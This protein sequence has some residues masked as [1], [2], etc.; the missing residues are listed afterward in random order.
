MG[1]YAPGTQ[2][3]DMANQ[4]GADRRARRSG[5]IASGLL[6]FAG[7]ANTL[8]S[9][10]QRN[11][12]YAD[13]QAAMPY[14]ADALANPNGSLSEG[15]QG[16]ARSP[17]QA[18]I[19]AGSRQPVESPSF[20][21]NLGT[22]FGFVPREGHLTPG[23]IAQIGEIQRGAN[24]ER[25]LSAAEARQ[26]QLFPLQRTALQFEN[27]KAQDAIQA[28]AEER[29][30]DQERFPYEMDVRKANVRNLAAQP[31]AAAAELDLKKSQAEENRAR[32]NYYNSGGGRSGA[33]GPRADIL[34]QKLNKAQLDYIDMSNVYAE[35]R[36]I[37]RGEVSGTNN[38]VFLHPKYASTSTDGLRQMMTEQLKL[39][40]SLQGGGQAP[41]QAGPTTAPPPGS[42][43]R[44]ITPRDAQ[45]MGTGGDATFDDFLEGKG[46]DPH[47]EDA[48]NAIPPGQWKALKDEFYGRG[49]GG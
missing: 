16:P 43:F 40:D 49:A 9:I 31:E 30:R 32:A 14:M 22:A 28:A 3:F 4:A 29:Q 8:S 47:N 21:H 5:D 41:G 11:Q 42:N 44:I 6:G 2:Q 45:S 36:K 37:E 18:A 12:A 34:A 39:I 27:A 26:E 10:N 1:R 17:M 38:P 35:K 23:A 48:I 25:R 7:L 24:S 20:L 33:T 19:D 13:Q 46:V 15:M